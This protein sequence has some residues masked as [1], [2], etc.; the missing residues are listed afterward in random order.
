MRCSPAL[1]CELARRSAEQS[2]GQADERPEELEHAVDRDA[3]QPEGEEQ[4]PDER[5]EKE[6]QEGE[7]P[8]QYQEDEPEQE[9]QHVEEYATGAAR[10]ST[11]R[12]GARLKTCATEIGESD[13]DHSSLITHRSSLITHHSSLIT[14]HPSPV[15]D[16]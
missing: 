5:I 7:R 3:Q 12:K 1:A 4:Q 15:T 14:H 8:A 9:L 6:S 16:H 10:G 11:G 2:A 13:P